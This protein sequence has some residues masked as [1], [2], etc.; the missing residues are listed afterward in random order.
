MKCWHGKNID[1]L[2]ARG[3]AQVTLTHDQLNQAINTSSFEFI[4]WFTNYQSPGRWYVDM[5]TR[6][7]VYYFERQEDATVFALKWV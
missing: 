2:Q 7:Y 1:L 4:D 3:W 6:D 5:S